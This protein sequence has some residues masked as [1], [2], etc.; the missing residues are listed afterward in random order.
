MTQSRVSVSEKTLKIIAM[1][2]MLVDHAAIG[3]WFYYWFYHGVDMRG[4]FTNSYI[5]E[6]RIFRL[7]GRIA[8]PLYCFMLVEG[9]VHTR[10]VKK[11]IGRLLLLAVVSE[12]PFD[13]AIYHKAI[14][15]DFNNVV[16]T[17]LLGLIAISVMYM[18]AESGFRAVSDNASIGM[19]VYYLAPVL[20]CFIAYFLHTDYGF[21]GVACIVLMYIMNV[22]KKMSP[23]IS[24]I[25]V[26]AILAL[27]SSWTEVAA[28]LGLIPLALY[29]GKQGHVTNGF[30]WFSYMF[31]PVHLLAIALIYFILL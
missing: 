12:I 4:W 21:L 9:F 5:L 16:W 2:T 11:Y 13:L 30:K 6:Y 10:N 22:E 31:Y 3:L 20:A 29:N 25:L 15:W 17:L 7:I 1:V 26:I 28:A 8:F 19:I 18:M 14:Y 24:Y 23:V 27:G